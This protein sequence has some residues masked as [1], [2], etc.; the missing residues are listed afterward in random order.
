MKSRMHGPRWVVWLCWVV[1]PALLTACVPIN[2]GTPAPVSEPPPAAEI[3]GPIRSYQAILRQEIQ[4]PQAD[5]STDSTGLE[6][7]YRWAA[8]DG[9]FGYNAHAV[10][11]ITDPFSGKMAVMD[12]AYLV[13]GLV[14]RLAWNGWNAQER[15]AQA[16]VESGVL[17]GPGG[18]F[19]DS[20]A[21]AQISGLPIPALLLHSAQLGEEWVGGLRATHY[22]L[23]DLSLL[24]A[25]ISSRLG[26]A[27]PATS[28]PLPTPAALHIESAQLD[29]WV[30][31]DSGLPIRY[32]FQAV[33]RRPG[34]MDTLIP[35]VLA[36]QYSLD[37]INA[38]LSV[39]VPAGI[40]AAV[41][42]NR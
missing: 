17:V 24:T 38:G 35:F 19:P 31:A 2:P 1:V 3:S 8:T 9:P 23:T 28:S 41:K 14:Y 18:T 6:Y 27:P 4:T 10:T 34:Q 30:G 7:T 16:G 29:L 42:A 25:P 26:I 32:T 40:L 22:Q 21:L 15:T 33:G 37:G 36:E 11:A 12:E 20:D 5:G 13:D 39:Q